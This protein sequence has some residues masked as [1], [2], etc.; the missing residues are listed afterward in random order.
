[1]VTLN[2]N[3]PTENKLMMLA[4]N[5]KRMYNI[6]KVCWCLNRYDME[7]Y[8][9]MN[10]PLSDNSWIELFKNVVEKLSKI[11]IPTVY[12]KAV[13]IDMENIIELPYN[14]IERYNVLMLEECNDKLQI[15]K[16]VKAS[17]VEENDLLALVGRHPFVD[18]KGWTITKV[19]FS[20]ELHEVIGIGQ[21]TLR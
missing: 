5:D 6:L 14:D 10:L 17:E 11:H 20:K 21:H 4:N 19:T 16:I 12:G 7:K 1:M 3:N 9:A 18:V 13:Q 15:T 8:M 2:G